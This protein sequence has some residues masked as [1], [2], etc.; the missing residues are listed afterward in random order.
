M[1]QSTITHAVKPWPDDD[2]EVIKVYYPDHDVYRIEISSPDI[3]GDMQNMT[4]EQA[5][6][7]SAAIASVTADCP[8]SPIP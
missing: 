7:L 2:L 4:V 1:A 5:A 6:A 3:S 8:D